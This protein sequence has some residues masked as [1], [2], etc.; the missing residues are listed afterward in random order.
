MMAGDLMNVGDKIKLFR[1]TAGISKGKLAL[2]AG[3]SAAY[4]GQL[5]SK[6]KQ[7]TVDTLSRICQALG[8]TLTEFFTEPH[9]QETLP[10]EARRIIEKVKKLSPEKLKILEPVLDSWIDND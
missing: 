9:E 10:P 3:V 6:N 8:I 4:I 5:E 1:E 2:D 7:P